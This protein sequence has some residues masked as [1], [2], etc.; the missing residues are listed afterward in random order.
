MN[1]LHIANLT[2]NKSVGPNVNVPKNI[3]YGNKIANVGLYNL[4]N[5]KLVIDIPKDKFFSLEKYQHIDR[6]PKPFD[7]PDI[8]V[9]QGVYF[10]KYCQIAK[11]LRKNN[12]PYIMVPRCSMTAAAIRSHLLKKKIANILFFNKLVAGAESIQFLTEN[13]YI[14]SKNNFKFKKHFVLGNGVEI[15]KKHYTVKNRKEFKIVFVGRYNVYHKGLDI[16]LDVVKNH[17]DW[18]RDNHVILEL[19]GSNSDNGLTYL[20]NHVDENCFGDVV[21]INGPAFDEAKEKALLDADVFIHTS[22][23]EGQPTSVIEAISYGI[24][25]IVTPGTNVSDVVKKYSLGFTSEFD[26]EAIFGCIKKAFARKDEFP[27]ISKNEVDYAK[28]HFIWPEIIKISLSEYNKL[29]GGR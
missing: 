8:V 6:L 27:V 3:L 15:P 14:E 26:L 29:L 12:I 21:K 24:P 11:W 25:V 16:L 18:F 10:V 20:T 22:R 5:T 7:K 19:Y 4:R 9:F 28:K 13:E 2:D 1:I 23:L 17:A